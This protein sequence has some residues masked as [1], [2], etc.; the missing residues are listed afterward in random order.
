MP[1]NRFA[2]IV[3]S[4]SKK[5]LPIWVSRGSREGAGRIMR[6]LSER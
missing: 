4:H 5:V 1:R 3:R 6:T 2:W